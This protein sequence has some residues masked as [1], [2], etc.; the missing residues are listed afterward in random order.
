M[1]VI[2]AHKQRKGRKKDDGAKPFS[3][4]AVIEAMATSCS[5]GVRLNTRK[6]FFIRGLEHWKR[7]PHRLWHL[8]PWRY[9]RIKQAEPWL[10]Q[11][12]VGC[13]PV[14]RWRLD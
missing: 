3:V 11:S 7:L 5:L 8:R 13:R 14:L 2:S 12:N 9:S 4:A 10:T 1:D 6:N